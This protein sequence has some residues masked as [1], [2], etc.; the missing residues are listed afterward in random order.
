M[1]SRRILS[2][3]AFL[4]CLLVTGC[5]SA[6]GNW[7]TPPSSD[8]SPAPTST[9]GT[10][11]R[12]IVTLDGV[13]YVHD[14]AQS[15]VTF[16]N[17]KSLLALLTKVA[18]EGPKVAK[19]EDLPGYSL[20]LTSYQWT[21]VKIIAGEGTARI[22][23]TGAALNGIPVQTDTGISIGSS[24]ADVVADDGKDVFDSNSDGVADQLALGSRVEPGTNSLSHPGSPGTSFIL[25]V[26]NEN[27]VQQIQSP[28]DDFSDL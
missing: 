7:G 6:T 21:G 25:L 2:F 10:S 28:S 5:S 11:D 15:E 4:V 17:S 13:T 14:G 22:S 1:S 16:E 3:T 12:L 20:N 9:P 23:I 26:M 8:A 18:G 24:R 19:V 27:T